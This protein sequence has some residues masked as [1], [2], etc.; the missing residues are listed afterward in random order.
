MP[1]EFYDW[2]DQCPVQWFYHADHHTDYVTYAFYK[3]HEEEEDD[4]TEEDL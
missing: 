4:E 1:K 2:L 3:P